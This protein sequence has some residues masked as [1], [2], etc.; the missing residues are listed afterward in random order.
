[1]APPPGP[2]GGVP[3]CSGD[4]D[5]AGLPILVAPPELW[6]GIGV[7]VGD[8]SDVEVGVVGGGTGGGALEC[9]PGIGEFVADAVGVQLQVSS[10]EDGGSLDGGGDEDSDSVDVG[11]SLGVGSTVCEVVGVGD[12]SLVE[13]AGSELGGGRVEWCV[14]GGLVVAGSVDVGGAD[15]DG[16]V[17]DDGPPAELAG[18][19]GLVGGW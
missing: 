17:D 11:C 8:G 14:D 19:D 5:G 9:P 4:V 16:G 6:V 7:G 13:G 12:G 18:R 3:L 2:T 15:V 1:L 10:G